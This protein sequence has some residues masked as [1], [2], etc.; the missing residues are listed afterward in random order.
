MTGKRERL[1]VSNVLD[2]PKFRV[3]FGIRTAC[4]EEY[5]QRQMLRGSGDAGKILRAFRGGCSCDELPGMSRLTRLRYGP[6]QL[7][8]GA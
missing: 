6:T 1:D 4:N 8:G 5:G 7:R 2:P 3:R